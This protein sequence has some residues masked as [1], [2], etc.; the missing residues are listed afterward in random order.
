MIQDESN[1]PQMTESEINELYSKIAIEIMEQMKKG[2]DIISM[3]NRDNIIELIA[4]IK[5]DESNYYY[6]HTDLKKGNESGIINF[7]KH[8]KIVY[9]A[10]KKEV[11]E[12]CNFDIIFYKIGE[13]CNG[14]KKRYAIIV[15][16]GL[17]SSKR[18]LKGFQKEKAKDKTK[19]LKDCKIALEEG[20]IRNKNP[21]EWHEPK[22]NYRMKIEYN[23]YKD[24]K[25]KEEKGKKKW[26]VFY[27]PSNEQRQE[28]KELLFGSNIDEN[29]IINNLKKVK[30]LIEESFSFYGILKILS[31]KNKVKKRKNQLNELKSFSNQSINGLINFGT[32]ILKDNLIEKFKKKE[33]VEPPIVPLKPSRLKQI[34]KPKKKLN[35]I[36]SNFQPIITSLPNNSTNIS[37]EF[38]I[39]E[40]NLNGPIDEDSL[41][42]TSHEMRNKLQKLKNCFPND[43]NG[44]NNQSQGIAFVI[45]NGIKVDNLQRGNEV[46]D[47]NNIENASLICFNKNK[48]EIIFK[49][50]NNQE[51]LNP[52]NIYDIS[53]VIANCN[54]ELNGQEDNNLILLGP[55]IDK[56]KGFEYSYKKDPSIDYIDPELIGI[57]YNNGTYPNERRNL[58]CI[59]IFQLIYELPSNK[60]NEI[61]NA[62]L[63][64]NIKINTDKPQ[65]DFY[66]Y[67]IVDIGNNHKKKSPLVKAKRY[68]NNHFVVEFN[69]QYYF[70][71]D[72]NKN[73][74][75]NVECF[76]IP[77]NC[78]EENMN[79][80]QKNFLVDYLKPYNLGNSEISINSIY[81]H[82]NEYDILKNGNKVSKKSKIL[83][84]G[85]NENSNEKPTIGMKGKDYS[86]GD[87]IYIVKT[88]NKDILDKAFKNSDL[89]N[90]I[91]EKY[92]DVKFDDYNNFLFR[93]PDNIPL[94]EFL[95]DIGN[96]IDESE[97]EKIQFNQKFKFLPQCEKFI[98]QENLA[99]S[100]NLAFLTKA[101]K[102]Q[103]IDEKREGEWI[104]KSPE[105]KV[106]ILSKNLGVDKNENLNQFNYF[107]NVTD[108]ISKNDFLDK[109]TVFPITE[110]NFNLL[111]MEYL[112]SS[113]LNNFNNYQWKISI[114]FNNEEQMR[115]FINALEDAKLKA[116]FVN[117]KELIPD[118]INY[119]K[120]L[121]NMGNIE[122]T[123][124]SINLGIRAIEF[125]EDYNLPFDSIMKFSIDKG[126]GNKGKSGKTL[127]EHLE[128]EEYNFEN[129]ILKN[130]EVKEKL[131]QIKNIKGDIIPI[132]GGKKLEKKAFN[133]GIRKYTFKNKLITKIPL[134]KGID[135]S[136]E[137]NIIFEGNNSLIEEFGCPI[138]FTD[139]IDK[140]ADI[141]HWAIYKKY[142]NERGEYVY[143][144]KVYGAL[145]TDSWD[146][147]LN[148]SFLNLFVKAHEF[149]LGSF[150]FD[151][152]D[153]KILPLGKFEPNVFRRKI[154]QRIHDLFNSS[155]EEILYKV[156]FE[157]NKTNFYDFLE[158]KC[159]QHPDMN[160]IDE[161]DFKDIRLNNSKDL[162]TNTFRKRLGIKTL[163]YKKSNEFYEIF[164]QAE[165]K[166]FLKE[167]V[168][169][170]YYI[171]NFESMFNELPENREEIFKNSYLA[172]R[173]SS[174]IY[175]GIPSKGRENVWEFLLN[176]KQLYNET[177]K[178]EGFKNLTREEI[179]KE[180]KKRNNEINI[181][182]SL[183]DNDI[184]Y[185]IKKDVIKD[186][187]IIKQITKAFFR[188]TEDGIKFQNN[189]KNTKYVYFSG[190]LSIVQR[191]YDFVQK[192]SSTFWL[193]IGL[194]Q[195]IDLF[196]QENPFYSEDMSYIN[197]YLLVIK[198]IIE[199]NLNDIYKKFLSLNFPI[200]TLISHNIASLFCDYFQGEIQMRIF[201]ILIFEAT[202]H[203]Y[204]GNN[205]QYLR[206]LCTIP[207]TLMTFKKK[208]ILNCESVSEL[209]SVFEDMIVGSYNINRFINRL[210]NNFKNYFTYGNFF[211]KWFGLSKNI[212]WDSK[213]D[214]IQKEIYY[215]FNP[216]RKENRKYLQPFE[217]N[218]YQKIIPNDTLTFIK[219]FSDNL[220]SK[221]E[222]VRKLYGYGTPSFDN[223]DS[224]YHGISFRINKFK[225]LFGNNNSEIKDN[226]KVNIAF[227]DNQIIN[228]NEIN[229]FDEQNLIMNPDDCSIIN[230]N[231]LYFDAQFPNEYFT[232]IF[233]HY[234]HIIITTKYNNSI[235]YFSFN[236][237]HFE[238]MKM[239]K[240][241][242]ESLGDDRK[243]YI[244]EINI[245]RYSMV[246]ISSDDISLFNALF[247]SPEYKHNY[248]IE[249]ELTYY[250]NSGRDFTN[251]VYSFIQEENNLKTTFL[252]YLPFKDDE[253]LSDLYLKYNIICTYP[254][255]YNNLNEKIL[256]KDSRD[257]FK[258]LITNKVEELLSKCF[259]EQI[260]NND[261]EKKND[262]LNVVPKIMEWLN[263]TNNSLEEI[264]YCFALIDKSS[265][266]I[267][268]K[269]YLLFS[270]GQMKNHIIF[271]NDK[272]SIIKVKEMIYA[273]YKRYMIYF[274]KNEVDRMIDFYLK[275]E[276]LF[277]LKY[278]LI[279]DSNYQK[280]ITELIYDQE[281]WLPFQGEIL[282]DNLDTQFNAYIN[283]F[284]NHFN[285]KSIPQSIVK[286]ILST[287]IKDGGNLYKYKEKNLD[288]IALV[289]SR[290]NI[291]YIHY[292][293]IVSY[294]QFRIEEGDTYI[295][296][297]NDKDN[298]Q[299]IVL[300]NEC[301]QLEINNSFSEKYEIS[302]EEFKELFFKLPFLSEL[303]RVSCSYMH[304]SKGLE[305]EEFENIKIEVILDDVRKEEFYFPE[306]LYNDNDEHNI[307]FHPRKSNSVKDLI[308]EII[309]NK[310]SSTVEFLRNPS[311]YI[312]EVVN[313]QTNIN[314]KILYLDSFYSNLFLKNNSKGIIKIIFNKQEMSIHGDDIIEKKEG[315]CKRYIDNDYF[316]WRKARINDNDNIATLVS[317]DYQ[318]KPDINENDIIKNFENKYN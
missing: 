95:N 286:K 58:I 1:L 65:D 44:N 282:Y 226:L 42:K 317:V 283:Y 291:Q 258:R 295:I 120:T 318:A 66:F 214:K 47:E 10:I 257:E 117:E 302:F 166:I 163:H 254:D 232:K 149:Y 240:I 197:I 299:D 23:P 251:T 287:I 21:P 40:S 121:A 72:E 154:I 130:D 196:Q 99:K 158:K 316:E 215:F 82:Q 83:I 110:N 32:R 285:M 86:I 175:L 102:D 184:N 300:C 179:Y 26:F 18:P 256:K 186:V 53:N 97:V 71:L 199:N 201:D 33:I 194:S 241:I 205:L 189:K 303:L 141:G 100:K 253:K 237:S 259:D 77:C 279:Y 112:D 101:E 284:V 296:N 124:C 28:V 107:S 127:L 24:S 5:E 164:A 177:K 93:P 218:E 261:N 103:I 278:A 306:N 79:E 209:Q 171:D 51:V 137:F 17:F 119:L 190:I 297:L 234:L 276:R 3:V 222:N 76:C 230:I 227:S 262:S 128:L 118:D 57:K 236:I 294:D 206:I 62:A 182:Y 109:E 293:K 231:D 195:C 274:T 208:N 90:E 12:S 268:E 4:K 148:S 228:T 98:N 217:D 123:N 84:F 126:R 225:P 289:I 221:L 260:E 140:N 13:K 192:E 8:N 159:V 56:N 298:I 266:T 281:R 210:K 170:K 25:K 161:W 74:I 50:D 129:S 176:V 94:E 22:F 139:T 144:D 200:E 73:K 247:S 229:S 131:Q 309:R 188:W 167:L 248:Y 146:P 310:H 138:D 15:K 160:N 142:I 34:N 134:R 168:K 7:T 174:V 165:W 150:S 92:Y 38:A 243:K 270:I 11:K 267:S 235:C 55:K 16:R 9:E 187:D 61:A 113:K 185:F 314:E 308:I 39:G 111:D 67:H 198:L 20:G 191:I 301:N 307:N 27:F 145:K 263:E 54:G 64:Q 132:K 89:P 288:T 273:L 246:S 45:N 43:F 91:K 269:L 181:V 172:E 41:F 203:S 19:Y 233:P 87:N 48:P 136:V 311:L 59:Q 135:K 272:I 252:S 31:V 242:L 223:S 313:T 96:Q 211:Q 2:K 277:N 212:A 312:C 290:D 69:K 122:E 114:K 157:E 173:M 219:T 275:D 244:I 115:T 220:E 152:N 104:Y 183:I 202:Y 46:M 151:S 68:K 153:G 63:R 133:S 35:Y 49:D 265:F 250:I 238:V 78:F 271:N 249:N 29:A 106:R 85:F 143:E 255:E 178:K 37:E 36:P 52:K 80:K 280:N 169:Q 14:W 245:F 213:R 315:Y 207:I 60:L 304:Q 108:Q 193:L 147:S 30:Y 224:K 156:R 6:C 75:I 155:P 88:I 305:D 116:N 292:Y 264:L 70:L 239:D 105:I 125:R 216:I 81:Q 162:I 204:L 180:Y